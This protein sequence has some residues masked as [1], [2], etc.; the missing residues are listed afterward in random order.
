MRKREEDEELIA[1]YY[2][3]APSILDGIMKERERVLILRS[4]YDVIQRTVSEVKANRPE[5]AVQTYH[6]MVERLHRR[7]APDAALQ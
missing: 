2:R 4:L 7:F 1:L 3:V 6:G 5:R